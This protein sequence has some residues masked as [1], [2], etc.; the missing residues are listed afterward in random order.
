MAH[1]IDHC[2]S[3][4]P[5]LSG[6]SHRP[7]LPA[8]VPGCCPP[9]APCI[10]CV[11]ASKRAS[12][13][14][15]DAFHHLSIIVVVRSPWHDPPSCSVSAS[16]TPGFPRGALVIFPSS[17]PKRPTCKES[18]HCQQ[19]ATRLGLSALLIVL[20][21]GFS[22]YDLTEL[23]PS[24]ASFPICRSGEG[25]ETRGAP[26]MCFPAD[27]MAGWLSLRFRD[28]ACGS[29]AWWSIWKQRDAA[30]ETERPGSRG[31]RGLDRAETLLLVCHQAVSSCLWLMRA[32][33]SSSS[34]QP[35]RI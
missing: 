3:P 17:Q 23:V 21:W 25:P 4:S 18:D 35:S 8:V 32:W 2:V 19:P 1:T 15:L 5:S 28:S 24:P 27:A 6:R 10:P 12:L 33:P 14:R 11:Q 16:P 13:T 22:H 20:V 9:P 29:S 26:V 31:V 30:M 7:Q 34:Q